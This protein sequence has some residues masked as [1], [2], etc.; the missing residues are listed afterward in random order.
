[1]CDHQEEE[2][3]EHQPLEALSKTHHTSNIFQKFV[4]F[5]D[6]FKHSQKFGKFYE[7]IESSDLS[8]TSKPVYAIFMG[9]ILLANRCQLREGNDSKHVKEEPTENIVCCYLLSVL[10]GLEVIIL[11]CG[12]EIDDN[13]DQK[14]EINNPFDRFPPYFDCVSIVK[15]DSRGGGDACPKKNNGNEQVPVSF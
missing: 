8:N 13:I 2:V 3:N 15:S 10:D 5:F 14:Q 6:D 4:F 12:V 7:F 11:V 9:L 1:M